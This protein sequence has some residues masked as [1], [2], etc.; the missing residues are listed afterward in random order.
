MVLYRKN[1][2]NRAAPRCGAESE[3]TMKEPC[4]TAE[5]IKQYARRLYEEEKSG[6]TIEKYVRDVRTFA[7]YAGAQALTKQLTIAYKRD[8]P[9]HG[10][11]VLSINSMLASLNSFLTF[12]GRSDCKVR[13][14][15]VQKKTY[16]A[17]DKELSR[18]EYQRLLKAARQDQR[19]WLLLQTLCATG[20]RVSELQYFT[21]ET[22]RH[23]EVCVAC[24]SKTRSILIP[25]GLQKLLLQY[26]RGAGIERGHIF[27]TR[28]G[29]PLDRSNI[30]SAM[31][32][33]CERA[34]VN[35]DKVFPHNLR[36]LFARSFYQVEKDLAKLA[37]LLGH[38]SINTTR[39]YIMSTGAEHRR[40]LERLQLLAQCTT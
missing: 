1:R 29:K 38:S 26:A 6:A 3:N 36:K 20:I 31:K 37:D 10:Y 7:Q 25:K 17:A 33:L 40:Q 4:I 2:Y 16:L 28:T 35:P 8:L 18:A 24:K 15:R 9:A 34:N 39:I 32:R 11:T 23:G 19:L 5:L 22:V 21:V 12:C 27:R 14:Y 13:L 30:W